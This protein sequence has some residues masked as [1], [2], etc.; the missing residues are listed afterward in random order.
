MISIIVGTHGGFGKE[1]IKTAEMIYGEQSLATAVSMLGSDSLDTTTAKFKAIIND[2]PKDNQVI[3]LTD[4]FG[5]TPFNVCAQIQA[6]SPQ[7][8]ELLSGVN[9]GMLL[10]ALMNNNRDVHGLADHLVEVGKSAINKFQISS[11]EEDDLL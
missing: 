7:R 3:F 8:F 6:T 4:L 5:G 2:L 9:L 1:L 10:E 11:D